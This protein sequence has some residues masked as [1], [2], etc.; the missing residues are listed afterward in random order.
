[1]RAQPN[2]FIA[3]IDRLLK[4]VQKKRRKQILEETIYRSFLM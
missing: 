2:P 4:D 3:C 1:M